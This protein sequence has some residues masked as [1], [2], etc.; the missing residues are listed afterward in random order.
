MGIWKGVAPAGRFSR[1]SPTHLGM[2]SPDFSIS[3]VEPRQTPIAS[4]KSWLCRVQR[5]TVVPHR[6]IGSKT[7]VGVIFPVRP[8]D[9]SMS[10]SFVSL[11][12]GGYL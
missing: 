3:S 6:R 12:S 5:E 7:A 1:T 9:S 8:T 11:R 2:T 4:M 10:R